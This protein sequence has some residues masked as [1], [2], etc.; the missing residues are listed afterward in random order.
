MLH[1]GYEDVGL[2]LIFWLSGYSLVLGHRFYTLQTHTHTYCH[3]CHFLDKA[4]RELA[5]L[6][7]TG[8]LAARGDGGYEPT[9]AS[10]VPCLW[11]SCPVTITDMHLV[12]YAMPIRY[13][14]SVSIRRPGRCVKWSRIST[15]VMSL[16]DV[17]PEISLYIVKCLPI[18]VSDLCRFS[19]M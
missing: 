11:R 13:T 18:E 14:R 10:S 4:H 16:R 9:G 17:C 8:P 15:D 1:A 3:A 12:L 7:P 6:V 19:V 2:Q 5:Q